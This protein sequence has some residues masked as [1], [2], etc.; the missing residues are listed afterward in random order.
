VGAVAFAPPVASP[1][2]E[3]GVE[4]EAPNNHE[5]MLLP[6]LLAAAAGA[7]AGAGAGTATGGFTPKM[8]DLLDTV[9]SAGKSPEPEEEEEEEELSAG[10]MLAAMFAA[11]LTHSGI[12]L[13]TRAKQ[14][15]SENELQFSEI[16]SYAPTLKGAALSLSITK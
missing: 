6:L 14:R 11:R 3:L 4:V 12:C 1:E 13:S 15:A 10:A 16:R 2:L 8:G 9:P 7:A 5:K